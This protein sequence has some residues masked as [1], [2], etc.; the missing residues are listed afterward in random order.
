MP[1][2]GRLSGPAHVVAKNVGGR[3]KVTDAHIA[4]FVV[5]RIISHGTVTPVTEVIRKTE[6]L[7]LRDRESTGMT[8]L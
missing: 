8:N 2:M 5:A 7:P 6:R 3:E 1:E 4:I